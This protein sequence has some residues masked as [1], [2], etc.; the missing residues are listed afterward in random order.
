M[1]KSQCKFTQKQDDEILHRCHL[2]P[3]DS[4]DVIMSCDGTKS[5]DV[6]MSRD[7]I[8]LCGFKFNSSLC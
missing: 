2:K 1:S 8:G 5:R 4:G 7:I 3:P 6:I